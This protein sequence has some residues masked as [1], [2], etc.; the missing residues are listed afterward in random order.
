MNRSTGRRRKASGSSS[1]RR[2]DPGHLGRSTGREGS[3][4]RDRRPNTGRDG[5]KPGGRNV[6]VAIL[7]GVGLAGLVGGLLYI[8]TTA[9]FGFALVVIMLAQAE[10][11]RAARRAGH[12][13]APA[14]GLVAGVLILM[15]VFTNDQ[16]A[17]ALVLFATLACSF[18]WYMGF[19]SR[20]NLLINVG[21]TMFGIV[22]IPLLGSFVGLLLSRPD[23]AEVTIVTLAAVA[24][25]DICAY[26]GGS[27]FGRRPMAPSISP[28]KTW[29]GALMG[30]VGTVVVILALAPLLG[31][32]NLGQAAILGGLISV[33]APVGDLVESM[34]K[35]D[36]GIKD[37]GSILPG[38]GGALD[39]IDAMLVAVPTSYLCLGLFGL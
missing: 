2:R 15:E 20:H 7:S 39:R 10:F 1:L 3:A 19:E 25:Y 38:H 13:P 9:F 26:A 30:T 28:N 29:E 5:T 33:V 14:L 17:A 6:K 24:V 34:I 37:M 8:G 16:S 36:F 22:Y 27:M 32:W 18:L 4:S 12:H 23:G 21:I 35:R 11:Y 31:P